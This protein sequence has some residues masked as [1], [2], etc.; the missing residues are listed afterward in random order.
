MLMLSLR[1]TICTTACTTE[2]IHSMLTVKQLD[3]AQ[4]RQSPYRLWDNDRSGFGAQVTPTGKISFFQLYH[5]DGKRKYLNLGRYPDKSLAD[6]RKQ[7][8]EARKL[9][10]DDIDPREHWEAARQEEEHRKAEAERQRQLN[11]SRG[12]FEQLLIAHVETLEQ[13][14]RTQE[15]IKDISG[16]LNRWVPRSLMAAKVADITPEDLR[17]VVGDA[18]RKASP[19]TAN[20]LHT[21]LHA[22]FKTGLHHDHNPANLGSELSFGLSTNPMD[23]IPSQPNSSG[24]RDRALQFSE[25]ARIWAA[26]PNA[27]GSPITKAEIKLQLLLGGMHF[28]EVGHARWNEFDFS[29]N[30]WELPATRGTNE[31][32]TKNRRAHIIPLCPMALAELE[33]LKP[34]TGHTPFVFPKVGAEQSAPMGNTT[35]A[36]FVRK[37]LRP[38]MDEQDKAQGQTPLESWSPANFR[39]TVK[40][41]LGEL[42]YSSEWRNRLQNHGQQGVDVKHYDRWDFLKQKRTM[43]EDFESHLADAIEAYKTI[44]KL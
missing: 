1:A 28:T 42:G 9:I 13:R 32:G 33:A 8:S 34:L 41:R 30:V 12:S 10:H 40:T 14:G 5:R 37:R 19:N 25:L 38:Y 31:A 27:P 36:Q 2:V 44:T 21:Y 35:S 23:A 18:I 11:E 43:L 39:S 3:T 4:P 20:R 26:L 29:K 16:T 22:V 15:Y 17:K 7:A 6:A 24:T